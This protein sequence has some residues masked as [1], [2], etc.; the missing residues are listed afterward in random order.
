MTIIQSEIGLHARPA[1]L[2]IQTANQFQ[3]DIRILHNDS[4]SNGTSLL[5]ILGLRVKKGKN[6]DRGKWRR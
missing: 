6:H 2:F 1:I 5:N 4:I 3:S